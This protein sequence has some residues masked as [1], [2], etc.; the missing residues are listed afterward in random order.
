MKADLT[1]THQFQLEKWVILPEIAFKWSIYPLANTSNWIFKKNSQSI[2]EWHF[3]TQ[4]YRHSKLTIHFNLELNK[5]PKSRI[6]QNNHPFWPY[7]FSQQLI[8]PQNTAEIILKQKTIWV[9]NSFCLF[10]L[11]SVKDRTN[12]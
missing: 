5:T 9:L 11:Q 1:L 3:R 10:I 2:Q 4:V 12:Q 8:K 7:V 6:F